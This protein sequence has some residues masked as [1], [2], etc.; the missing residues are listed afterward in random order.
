MSPKKTR[1]QLIGYKH[2]EQAVADD[3]NMEKG[4]HP[5]I[6]EWYAFVTVGPIYHGLLVAITPTHYIL[7][8]MS[9]VCDTGRLNEFVTN[10]K[11]NAK[12]VEYVG[13]GG[14]ARSAEMGFYVVPEGSL[15][16]R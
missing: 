11:K 9:W 10:P 4:I 6:G 3:Q 16:T 14:C 8:E 13:D 5:R 12:E 1:E 7:K 2:Q 15:E